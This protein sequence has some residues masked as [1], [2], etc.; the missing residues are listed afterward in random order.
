MDNP[1]QV[2][3]IA[4]RRNDRF[5]RPDASA[6][7]CIIGAEK[8]TYC[9]GFVYANSTVQTGQGGGS[10]ISAESGIDDIYSPGREFFR[11]YIHITGVGSSQ[12]VSET[13]QPFT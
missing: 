4:L 3:E 7:C 5:I 12:T 2:P 13:D 11:Q 9:V 8:N 1:L 10:F 6:D